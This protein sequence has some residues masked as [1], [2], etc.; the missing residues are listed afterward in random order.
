MNENI[1]FVVNPNCEC[2][3]SLAIQLIE[4]DKV[5]SHIIKTLIEAGEL[6]GRQLNE[7][8]NLMKEQA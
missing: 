1:G 3:R 5:D 8:E 6:L 4:M 7:L 2:C